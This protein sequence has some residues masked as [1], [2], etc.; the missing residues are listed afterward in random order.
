MDN[1]LNARIVLRYATY[2]RWMNSSAILYKGEVAVAEFSNYSTIYNMSNSTPANTPPAIGI[3][4]GNGRD[5]FANLPWVQAIAAD[6]YNWAKS[7]VKPTYS[8]S[9]IT[10]LATYIENHSGGSSGSTAY[11]QYQII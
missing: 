8:A 11:R 2:E 5:T 10:G 9:E 6:V 4:I 1:I 3:K 7:S